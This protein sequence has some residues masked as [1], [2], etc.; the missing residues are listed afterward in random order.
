MKDT[1]WKRMFEELLDLA[2]TCVCNDHAGWDS[3]L[4]E[5]IAAYF[6]EDEEGDNEN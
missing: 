2:H 4:G 3:P 6:P 1:D 5:A